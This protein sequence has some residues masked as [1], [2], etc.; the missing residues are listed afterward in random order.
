MIY[1]PIGYVGHKKSEEL[2][3]MVSFFLF[4]M[5]PIDSIGAGVR[6]SLQLDEVWLLKIKQRGGGI[7]VFQGLVF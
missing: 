5:L 4:Q 1:R 2:S 3:D 6:K 7:N